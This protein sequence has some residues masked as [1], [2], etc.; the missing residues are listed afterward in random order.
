VL[1]HTLEIEDQVEW[2]HEK[3]LAEELVRKAEGGSLA[4]SGVG[5]TLG[6]LTRGEAQ[7]LLVE[8]GFET[9]GFV[10]YHCHYTSLSEDMCPQCRKRLEPCRDIVDEAI[11]LALTKNC[12]IEHVRGPT[13]LRDAGRMGALLR[14]HS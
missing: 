1:S 8:D 3:Q 7:T 2:E 13:A 12:Q 4:V 14:F 10:C 5:A 9:P 11:E 6:A